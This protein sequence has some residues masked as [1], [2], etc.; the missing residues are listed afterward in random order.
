MAV[1]SRLPVEANGAVHA[2]LEHGPS[3]AVHHLAVHVVHAVGAVRLDL[4]NAANCEALFI[5]VMAV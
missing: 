4:V 5:H 2:T 3:R 1:G